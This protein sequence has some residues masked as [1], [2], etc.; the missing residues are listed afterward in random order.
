MAALYKIVVTSVF[1]GQIS[2]PLVNVFGYRSN[3]VVVNEASE[4]SIAFRAQMVPELI[5]VMQVSTEIKRV[6]V[7]NVTNGV[8]YNDYNYAATPDG[9][10]AGESTSLFTAWGFQ[11]NRATAGKRNGSK[12]FGAVSETDVQAGAPTVAM[13][14]VLDALAVK[15][16]S[17]LKI[18]LIDTW[19]PEIL[20][21]KP[22][23]VYPWTSHPI[24]NVTF[25]RV[26]TQ[27]SR[28]QYA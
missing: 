21:R 1:G 3:L 18:G 26:T 20:E 6:E 5:K 19:F 25:K 28:K 4:L 12:R 23:G 7:L 2:N 16:G 10:R 22:T 15:L 13:T 27:N 24:T 17:P 14:V 11:Y 9:L 8:E